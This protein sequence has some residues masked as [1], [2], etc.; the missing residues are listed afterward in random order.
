MRGKPSKSLEVEKGKIIILKLLNFKDLLYIYISHSLWNILF[1]ALSFSSLIELLMECV[2]RAR[3]GL[4]NLYLCRS[5]WVR[6][7]FGKTGG[8]VLTYP[9]VLH[10]SLPEGQSLGLI[11]QGRLLLLS[12]S[13]FLC[14]CTENGLKD[15]IP[16]GEERTHYNQWHR[17]K[18]D[19]RSLL[20]RVTGHQIWQ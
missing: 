12:H 6:P 5:E 15:W 13:C 1:A 4:E 9:Q 16:H 7:F 3:Y 20:W 10:S 11:L 19:C 8:M 2:M 17:D 18:K 14:W